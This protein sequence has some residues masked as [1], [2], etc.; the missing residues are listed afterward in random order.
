M[1][2]HAL[3]T[4]IHIYMLENDC[5]CVICRYSWPMKEIWDKKDKNN[6]NNKK[7]IYCILYWLYINCILDI[8]IN[9]HI[10]DLNRNLSRLDKYSVDKEPSTDPPQS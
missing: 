6:Y 9:S 4:Y 7:N 3:H 2:V 8:E 1:Y 5:P 10:L